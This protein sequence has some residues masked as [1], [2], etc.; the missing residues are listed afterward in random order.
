M[1][2]FC[3]SIHRKF[4]TTVEKDGECALGNRS[5]SVFVVFCPLEVAAFAVI[6]LFFVDA[7]VFNEVRVLTALTV[8]AVDPLGSYVKLYMR[9][10]DVSLFVK[11]NRTDF[12]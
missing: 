8:H 10:P 9:I 5:A 12:S 11:K 4:P 3:D 1:K 2:H 7:L 6:G